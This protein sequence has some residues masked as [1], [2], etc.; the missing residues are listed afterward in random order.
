MQMAT[1]HIDQA[2]Q[3]A[4]LPQIDTAVVQ[5]LRSGVYMNLIGGAFSQCVLAGSSQTSDGCMSAEFST[6][7]RLSVYSFSEFR[8]GPR[9]DPVRLRC[10]DLECT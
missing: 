8:L 1:G 5:S 9:T 7:R 10:A 3:L 4:D 6:S 2:K